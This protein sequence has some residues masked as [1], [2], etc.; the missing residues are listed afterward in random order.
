MS[1][2]T[3]GQVGK[4]VSVCEEVGHAGKYHERFDG[5]GALGLDL[6]VL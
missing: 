5:S 6:W 3:V 4:R 2:A 1:P